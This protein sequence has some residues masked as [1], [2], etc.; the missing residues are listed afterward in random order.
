[1]I[2]IEQLG[3]YGTESANT[4]FLIR[5]ILVFCILSRFYI[6]INDKIGN[7]LSLSSDKTKWKGGKRK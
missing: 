6:C 3:Q 7:A 5:A 1:M 4:D 2:Q